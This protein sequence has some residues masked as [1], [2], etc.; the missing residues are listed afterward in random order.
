CDQLQSIL[1]GNV[2][3]PGD[4]VYQRQQSSYYSEQQ[5]T[6]N[7]TCRVTPTSAQDL[8]QII[9]IAASMNCSFAVRSGGHMNWPNS[10]NIND[11]GFTIDMENL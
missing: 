9:T 7:P 6:V 5:K 4:P 8:S 10:S 11:I 3:M 2:F 1:P